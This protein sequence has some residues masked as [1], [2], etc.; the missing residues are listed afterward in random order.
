MG[1]VSLVLISGYQMTVKQAFLTQGKEAAYLMPFYGMM[2]GAP[3]AEALARSTY[4]PQFTGPAGLKGGFQHYGPL[5]EDGRDNRAVFAG[6]LPMPVLVL[7]G[8]KGLPQ[9]PLL[10]GARAVAAQVEAAVIPAA[11]HTYAH[12][13]PERTA[14]RLLAFLR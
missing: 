14:E 2:S 9:V 10:N 3:D 5:V 4:L 6:K 8:E 11:A 7:N 12:E 13:N 1:W